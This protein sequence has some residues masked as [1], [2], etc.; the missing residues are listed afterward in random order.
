MWQCKICQCHH[1]VTLNFLLIKCLDVLYV[2]V[3][4]ARACAH[5]HTQTTYQLYYYIE[6]DLSMVLS[7]SLSVIYLVVNVILLVYKFLC[8][9]IF[10]NRYLTHT[11]RSTMASLIKD[12]QIIKLMSKNDLQHVLFRFLENL[13]TT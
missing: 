9:L 13:A 2:C 8:A 3:R 6:Y 4:H 10:A 1:I 7:N 12:Y 11:Y 5:T